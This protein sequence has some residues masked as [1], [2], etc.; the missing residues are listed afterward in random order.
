MPHFA[1]VRV[2]LITTAVVRKML[3]LIESS[4][5]G[6]KRNA[7]LK[8]STILRSAVIDGLISR[9]PAESLQLPKRTIKEIDPF[10]LEEANEIITRL[11]EHPHW[12]SQIY[13]AFFEFVFLTDLRLS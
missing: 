5:P 3:S 6:V 1:L 4:S 8:L 9:N 10:T 7:L 13:A 11:Y 2:D 12:P